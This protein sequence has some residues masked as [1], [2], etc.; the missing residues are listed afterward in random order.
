MNYVVCLKYGNKYS[1]EYVNKLYSMVKRNLTIPFEFVCYTED[2]TGI[3]TNIKTESLIVIPGV[4]GWWYKPMFFNPALGLQGTIL[5]FDLDVVIFDNI[6]NLF[7]YEPN[8]FCIIRDFNRHV[9]RNYNKFNSSIFRLTTGMH[10]EIYT[11]FMKDPNVPIRRYHGDQDWIRSMV[12]DGTYVYWPDEWIQSYKWEMRGKPRFN[13][14][15]RGHR[16][17]EVNG[18]PVIKNNTSIA[19]FHGEPQPHNCKDQW[20]VDNWK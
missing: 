10:S 9:V 11:S 19:V 1:A 4:T 17:F 3:D 12:K 7:S 13:N 15:P 20:V 14:S 6:D 5:F 8:K 2:A 16:D 18:D